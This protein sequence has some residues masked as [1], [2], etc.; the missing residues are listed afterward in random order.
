MTEEEKIKYDAYI[1]A[2][3]EYYALET[4]EQ[5]KLDNNA[6][7]FAMALIAASF[8]Y[9]T[10][11]GNSNK[12][13]YLGALYLVWILGFLS[14]ASVYFSSFFSV[15]NSKECQNELEKCYAEKGD[16]YSF[17]C[18]RYA[19]ITSFLNGA[20]LIFFLIA[21]ISL[22]FFVY[23]NPIGIIASNCPCITEIVK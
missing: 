4:S 20:S 9:F 6:T 23:V 7:L 10:Y 19:K 22:I 18:A 3:N 16:V 15:K 14:L 2:R 21:L 1:N 13:Y 11:I 5:N 17:H 8:A 12:V